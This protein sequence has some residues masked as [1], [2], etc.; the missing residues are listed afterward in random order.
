[1]LK[2]DLFHTRRT[3]LPYL[4]LAAARRSGQ[5]GMRGREQRLK[6]QQHSQNQH[7]KRQTNDAKLLLNP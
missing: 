6:I 2:S 7:Q 4:L 5:L 3:R 1:M